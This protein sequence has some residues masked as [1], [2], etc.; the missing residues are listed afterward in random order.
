[1]LQTRD[2]EDGVAVSVSLREPMLISMPA[3]WCPKNGMSWIWDR[4]ETKTKERHCRCLITQTQWTSVHFIWSHSNLTSGLVVTCGLK[5]IWKCLSHSSAA[6]PDTYFP[7]LITAN[8]TFLSSLIFLSTPPSSACLCFRLRSSGREAKEEGWGACGGVPL[9]F[10]N[11]SG[12]RL[13]SE[14]HL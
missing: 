11:I 1:M 14:S 8:R 9:A 3:V 5:N 2:C 4:G 10:F 13:C 7:L 12:A 6:A